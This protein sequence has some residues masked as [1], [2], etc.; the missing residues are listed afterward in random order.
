MNMHYVAIHA[1]NHTFRNDTNY[2]FQITNK[3]CIY[4]HVEV[5]NHAS[6]EVAVVL[7]HLDKAHLQYVYTTLTHTQLL[8][9]HWTTNTK[10]R[11]EN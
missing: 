9:Q 3:M 5:Q 4:Q 8:K 7:K 1:T 10:L 11:N 2:K 6:C